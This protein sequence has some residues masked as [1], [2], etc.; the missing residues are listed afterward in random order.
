MLSIEC[1][2]QLCGSFAVAGLVFGLWSLVFASLGG[3]AVVIVVSLDKSE[4]TAASWRHFTCVVSA[5]A[6]VFVAIIILRTE[7]V[8]S[9][10]IMSLMAG[11]SINELA[12]P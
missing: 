11:E 7:S 3:G 8:V 1:R 12:L 4:N 5:V 2:V 10:I 9:G 6:L